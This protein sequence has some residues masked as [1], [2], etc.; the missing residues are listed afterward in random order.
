MPLCFGSLLRKRSNS[1]KLPQIQEEMEMNVL[2]IG[3]AVIDI[4]ARPVSKEDDWQEKQS[5]E[6]IGI[7]LGGDAVNQGVYLKRLG[8]DCGL[9]IC[10]G[11]D[12]TGQML[13]GTLRQQGI[14]TSRV[15]VREGARTGTSMILV[16]RNGERRIFSATGVEREIRMED[17]PDPI[18]EGVQ[19]I[20]LASL[21]GLDNLERDG[22]EDYLA[23]ARKRGILVFA[24]TV[25]DKYQLG[26]DGIRHLLPQIDYF[27]P[28]LYE[29]Q[30]L[31][32][33]DTPEQTAA[34]FRQLGVKNVLIKCGG[35]GIYMDAST[36][37][38]WVSAMKVDPL[39]TT[40]AGDCFVAS[41]LTG[42]VKGY[43]EKEACAMACC[44]ASYSTLFLGASTA[45]LS[46][47]KVRT[48]AQ[49]HGGLII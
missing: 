47:E 11:A 16:D 41:F 15:C 13:K 28:S 33:T 36:Y 9:V 19:A 14:D 38:G 20:T 31:T 4:T 7:Q 44:A 23:R 10:V 18:P 42:I 6:E 48:L 40:G 21:Y 17:L 1:E 49:K 30:A 43:S 8:M 39:D 5:I 12:S 32:G 25:Y 46:W 35:D 34:A 37:T 27:L 22:L 24:D 45:D 29:A 26:L 3:L 2:C